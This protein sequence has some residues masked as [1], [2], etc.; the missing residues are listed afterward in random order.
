M[1]ALMFLGGDIERRLGRGAYLFF[2]MICL[3]GGSV[4]FLLLGSADAIGAGYSGVIYGLMAA[5]A[6]LWPDR[7]IYIFYMFPMKMKW[8]MLLLALTALFL[9]IE[10]GDNAIA[11]AA[12]V[13]GAL[14]GFLFIKLWLPERRL[15]QNAKLAGDTSPTD[16]TTKRKTRRSLTVRVPKQL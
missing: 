7:V 12:H 15:K 16:H 4:G 2:S 13:G 6:V 3:L 5:C 1:L 8:A 14:G 10:P 11:H 9:T